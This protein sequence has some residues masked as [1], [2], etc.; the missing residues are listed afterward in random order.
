LNCHKNFLA[1]QDLTGTAQMP[2]PTNIDLSNY[3]LLARYNLPEPTRTT[4]PANSL[5][6]QEV[7]AVTYNWDTESL[8]VVGDAG[9]SIVQ[10][11]KTGQLISSMT[12]A[13]GISPQ[14]TEFYDPE[15][16]T[17]IG[18]G[19]FVMTEERDRQVVKFTYVADTTLTRAN[20]QSVDLGTFVQNIG[21]EGITYDP[22]TGGFILAGEVTPQEVFQTNIDFAV[23]TATNGSATTVNH[24][25]LFDPSLLGVLDLA[26]VFAL[27][28]ITSLNGQP[29]SGNLLVLSQESGQIIE[30]DRAGNIY[31]SLTITTNPGNPL[32]VPAQQH[33][34]LTMDAEGNL[35]VVSENG[36]GDFDHPQLWVYAPS[37]APN[38]A[39]TTLALTN[40]VSA[41]DENVSTTLRVK[42]ADIALTDD[43][44]GTNNYTVTGADAAFFEV[45]SNGLYIKAGTVLDFETKTSYA[46]TVNVDDPAVGMTP[47]ASS[48]YNLTVNNIINEN[49]AQPVLY[50]SEV[51]PW[52]S[53][54]SPVASDWFEVTNG[55]GSAIDITGWKFDDNSNTFV[56]AVA[57]NGITSIG[58]G[59]SVIF[60]ECATPADLAAKATAFIQTWFGGIA[61][62]G[63]QIGSYSGSGIGL[64]T[65]GDAV[66]LYNATG[67]LQANVS[68][69]VSPAGPYPTFNNAVG[70]NN[71][72]IS[73]LSAVGTNGAKIAINDAAEVGSPGTVGRVIISEV[74]PWS[75]GNSPAALAADWFEVTNTTA[76]AVDMT[77]WKI[78]DNSGSPVAAVM[79][80]GVTS[81]APGQSVIFIETASPTALA[82]KAAAF[83]QIWFGGNPP[84]NLAIGSYSGAGVG[85]GAGGDA[86]NL[87]NA[88]GILQASV[89]FGA[90]PA[91]P[92]ATFDNAIGLNGVVISQLS[93]T[94]F[95]AAFLA[96]GDATEIGSPGY[97][98]PVVIN[99]TSA[100]EVLGGTPGNDTMFGDAGNDTIDGMGG[101]D[102]LG[103][104]TG[105]DTVLGGAGQDVILVG[106][107]LVGDF[108]VLNG[109]T[110]RDLLD[111]SGLTN[112]G[113]WIDFGYNV[114]SGPN[115]ASGFNLSMVAGEARVVEF[116]SIVGTAFNDTMRGDAGSNVIDGG[117]GDDILLSYSPYDTLTLYSSLGDVMLGGIGDDLLFSGTGNDYLDGGANNDILEV[118]GGTDTVVTG[119][120]SD[121]IFFSPRNG[122]D[123]VT[124]FTGGAGVVD[125]LKLYGFGTSL[126]S[127]AEVFA[128]SSQVGTDTHI[129]LTDTTIIL[130]NV[131]RTSLVADDFVFV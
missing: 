115:T 116:D 31:S 87:Y 23:G 22:Q 48:T 20:A 11:S 110:D 75:S 58:A 32:T 92:Y 127:F 82:A 56:N 49:P 106:N 69:G 40:Q 76:F 60:L 79:L 43:G 130:Q 93:S 63:L 122:T 120:G 30:V 12:L 124:D 111:I 118:G 121:T 41:I 19:Q 90:S 8:F 114:I 24:T 85:L 70:Q 104:G 34:G 84:A 117:A 71:T 119:T 86:V 66:N 65:G 2:Q 4:P 21:L 37:A 126:D 67:V 74:A 44:I 113:I 78:D 57:L 108:D 96:A 25:N 81:I 5:L 54:N 123:T 128:A 61:P 26:D 99:G 7:S 97:I 36:G 16:L 52:S 1:V 95:N 77:G 131:L 38:Q 45:D 112:G 83:I 51:A 94:G 47:D 46:V 59:Q 72:I 39:P 80:N 42:V 100:G 62:A 18:N 109:G 105:S 28:N 29:D 6:A 68:F 33:E 88:S 107:G 50:I 103:G 129:A 73:T 17:Y 9:T 10:V 102:T 101:N 125:V 3:M 64:S 35:Y 91:G 15:G 27:S 55:G 89:S 14:G 53:G 98:A 13:T